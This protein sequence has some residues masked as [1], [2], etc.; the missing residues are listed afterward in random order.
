MRVFIIEEGF[1][2][3]LAGKESTCNAG[4]LGLI[5]GLGRSL[6]EGHGNPL[7]YSCLENSMDR[8]TWQE[9]VHRVAEELD[10]T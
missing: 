10:M 9:T 3:R 8:G 7:Q 5:L 1:P 2:P 6:G 4:D